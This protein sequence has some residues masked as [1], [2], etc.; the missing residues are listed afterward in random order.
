MTEDYKA[1]IAAIMA[2]NDFSS[3]DWD[4]IPN[5]AQ[6]AMV[7]A[8]ALN[9]LRLT[10]L[11]TN[12][13]FLLEAIDTIHGNLC[14]GQLATWQGRVRQAIM[15]SSEL[16]W[17]DCATDHPDDEVTVMLYVEQ[18]GD[19]DGEGMI[20]EGFYLGGQWI[21]ADAKATFADHPAKWMHIPY[22]DRKVNPTV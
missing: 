11:E 16:V 2:Y 22:P 21:M 3:E 1:A 8:W 7:R 6:T 4:S 17:H 9:N 12:N 13:K 14:P 20:V 18:E 19:K 10:Q 5:K 15:R